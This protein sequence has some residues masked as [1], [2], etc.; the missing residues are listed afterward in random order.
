M[1]T[2]PTT[3]NTSD[4]SF[5]LLKMTKICKQLDNTTKRLERILE[6]DDDK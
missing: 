3:F 1:K 6:K 5:F 2:Y 4:I